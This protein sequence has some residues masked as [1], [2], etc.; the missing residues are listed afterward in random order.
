MNTEAKAYDHASASR[1]KEIKRELQEQLSQLKSE[2]HEEV[3]AE[4]N[5]LEEDEEE[6]DVETAQS[7]I[8]AVGTSITSVK[9]EMIA[10]K[11]SHH[12]RER[13]STLIRQLEHQYSTLSASSPRSERK[14]IAKQMRSVVEQLKEI[15]QENTSTMLTKITSKKTHSLEED[16]EKKQKVLEDISSVES[17]LASAHLS[18]SDREDAQNI[19]SEMRSDVDETS[20]MHELKSSLMSKMHQLEAVMGKKETQHKS[21]VSQIHD[22]VQEVENSLEFKKLPAAAKKSVKA[23][24]RD[25]D[26]QAAAWIPASSSE[27][28]KIKASMKRDMNN[29]QRQ[30]EEKEEESMDL[31]EASN[32][33]EDD[34]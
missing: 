3:A 11:L 32:E 4:S 14:Q 13:A 27:K 18:A 34:E 24:L 33:E 22:D 20:N 8:D 28:A 21:K 25:I 1:K 23:S 10:R 9:E 15:P 17:E 31:E 19:L 6:E 30:M 26:T 29:I 2:M 16:E 12:D 5:K 7:K